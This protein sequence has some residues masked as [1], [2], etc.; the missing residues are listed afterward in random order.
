M[1]H[2]FVTESVKRFADAKGEVKFIH[3][4]HTNALLRADAPA[5]PAGFGVAREGDSFAL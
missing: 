2:P 3:L 5:L 4:N 1:R